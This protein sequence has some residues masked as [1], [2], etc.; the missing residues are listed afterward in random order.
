[1]SQAQPKNNIINNVQPNVPQ[2]PQAPVQPQVPQQQGQPQQAP[3][4][5]GQHHHPHA[6]HR[7]LNLGECETEDEVLDAIEQSRRVTRLIISA[8]QKGSNFEVSQILEHYG[9]PMTSRLHF[10][11]VSI[12]MEQW[13]SLM[14]IEDEEQIWGILRKNEYA[15]EKI[16]SI[17]PKGT[18]F[19]SDLLTEWELPIGGLQSKI[20][21][22]ITDHLDEEIKL[23][24]KI[25]FK[26]A[27]NNNNM[28]N[29]A[30]INNHNHHKNNKI[31]N[32]A[33][34]EVDE[35]LQEENIQQPPKQN[36]YVINNNNNNNNDVIN[37][38]NPI[39]KDNNVNQ[40]E[41]KEQETS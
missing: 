25:P 33:N 39:S 26:N 8:V 2:Q 37:N 15:M 9:L 36:I 16:R 23:G 17:A 14:G 7:R 21:R 11:V 40:E 35:K 28:N 5:Q 4:Q 12:V 31:N 19:L 20:I 30:N 34:K 13:F 29:N 3:Q 24:H 18:I 10:K 1:M 38:D 32:N 41:A 27:N 6:Y 22:R